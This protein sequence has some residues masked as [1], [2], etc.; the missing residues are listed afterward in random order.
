M[1]RVSRR[2]VEGTSF[3]NVDGGG[4]RV[5]AGRP[6]TLR[7]LLRWARRLE[8]MRGGAVAHPPGQDEGGSLPPKVELPVQEAADVPGGMLPAGVGKRRVLEAVAGCWRRGTRQPLSYTTTSS[9]SPVER[10]AAAVQM[11]EPVLLA[12]RDGNG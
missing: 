1:V 9:A 2:G 7:D 3:A 4:P 8:R 11:T 12:G 10:V 6:F 5:H